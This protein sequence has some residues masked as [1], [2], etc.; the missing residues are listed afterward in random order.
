MTG[1]EAILAGSAY[2]LGLLSINNTVKKPAITHE[3]IETPISYIGEKLLETAIMLPKQI[4]IINE[5]FKFLLMQSFTHNA[6]LRGSFRLAKIGDKG[7]RA[8]RDE[9]FYLS[10]LL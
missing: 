4:P 1:R 2:R 7:A 3:T 5:I 6:S 10:D 8:S 9:S